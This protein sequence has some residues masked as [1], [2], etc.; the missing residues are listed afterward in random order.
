MP[1]PFIADGLPD[2]SAARSFVIGLKLVAAVAIL[3]PAGC[4]PSGR[5]GSRG[6]VVEIETVEVLDPATQAVRK[7][8]PTP[9]RG[10]GRAAALVVGQRAG[11]GVTS[12]PVPLVVGTSK[13]GKRGP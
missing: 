3:F 13:S 8:A 2:S 4:A 6:E 5:S 12:E 7:D 9:P 11:D 10:G 1:R